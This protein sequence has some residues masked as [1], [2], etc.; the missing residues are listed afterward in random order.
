MKEN[1]TYGKLTKN[2]NV[3]KWIDENVAL[4]TGQDRLDRWFKGAN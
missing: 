2:Q 4:V 3:L 1:N